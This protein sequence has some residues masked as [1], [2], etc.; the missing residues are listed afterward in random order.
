MKKKIFLMKK[1][2]SILILCAFTMNTIVPPSLAQSI[3]STILPPVGSMLTMT[4]SFVP[5]Q[6]KGLTIDPENPLHFEFIIDTGDSKIVNDEELRAET[7]KLVKYFLTSLTVPEEDMWVNLSP[8][9]GNRIVTDGFG[10][11]Q[12][13]QDLLAQDYILKQITASL[14]FP[15]KELGKKFWDKI[16]QRAEQEYGTK[17]IPTNT[18]NKVWIIPEKATVY[19]HDGSV[20]VIESRLK[21]LLE[22]DY[23][24]QRK[25]EGASVDPNKSVY[26]DI[27]REI[28]I[29]EIEKEVNE[30]QHFAKLRQIYNAMIL[31]TWYKTN[32]QKSVLGQIYVDQN[33]LEGING[34]NKNAKSD[35]YN[36]YLKAFKAGVYNYI[37][38]D[39]D[40][41]TRSTIPRQY[42]SGG[43]AA[44][45]DK[46]ALSTVV[47]ESNLGQNNTPLSDE[48]SALIADALSARGK[49]FNTDIL[50]REAVSGITS[51]DEAILS[52]FTED[53]IVSRI[54]NTPYDP[55]KIGQQ[56]RAWYADGNLDAD[57]LK[58]TLTNLSRRV[59]YVKSTADLKDY[60]KMKPFLIK[61][62]AL[63]K[64]ANDSQYTESISIIERTMAYS[65]Y[66]SDPKL[67]YAEPIESMVADLR[68]IKD[69]TADE[70]IKFDEAWTLISKRYS[71]KNP[72]DIF[73]IARAMKRPKAS[74]I[75]KSSL[76]KDF[77]ELRD[78]KDP[79]DPQ[80][81]ERYTP[82]ENEIQEAM[83]I[84][85][86]D[87]LEAR[88]YV[89]AKRD[90]QY[91]DASVLTGIGT[92]VD[93]KT[94]KET[95]VMVVALQNGSDIKEL[96]ER[97]AGLN[98]PWGYWKAIRAFRLAEST[99]YR[100]PIVTFVDTK[101]ADNTLPSEIANQSGVVSYAIQ[102]QQELTVPFIS[103][104]NIDGVSAGGMVVTQGGALYMMD[105][106][107]RY[108]AAPAGSLDIIGKAK[109]TIPVAEQRG[110]KDTIGMQIIE[111]EVQSVWGDAFH[112]DAK[113]SLEELKTISGIIPEA[114]GGAH[115]FPELS[116]EMIGDVIHNYLK[117]NANKTVAQLKAQRHDFFR[118]LGGIPEKDFRIV[119]DQDVPTL[120]KSIITPDEFAQ[121][122][123]TILDNKQNTERMLHAYRQYTFTLKSAKQKKE[124]VAVWMK[125]FRANRSWFDNRWMVKVLN[126]SL[127][128]F[129]KKGTQ[130][131]KTLKE[132]MIKSF[133]PEPRSIADRLEQFVDRKKDGSLEIIEELNANLAET[134][135]IDFDETIH[136]AYP[137]LKIDGQDIAAKFDQFRKLTGSLTGVW[138]GYVKIGG[139]KTMLV[140]KDPR[141][142]NASATTAVIGEKV[143]RALEDVRQ[144][145]DKTKEKIPVIML[146]TASGAL[147]QEGQR[148]MD[149][150]NKKL[151][152]LVELKERNIPVVILG[153][154]EVFGG[155]SASDATYQDADLLLL[156]KGTRK[157]F[158]GHPTL[159]GENDRRKKK[160]V[161]DTSQNEVVPL[162]VLPFPYQTDQFL[163][164][165]GFIDGIVTVEQETP[166]LQA[167]LQDVTNK[168][169]TVKSEEI[170]ELLKT[171]K[172]KR[173][174]R[175]K[176]VRALERKPFKTTFQNGNEA[177]VFNLRN[178]A[179]LLMNQPG[180]GWRYEKPA[181]G[182]E[183]VNSDEAMLTNV[184]ENAETM[185]QNLPQDIE[186]FMM[187][188]ASK[189]NGGEA[190][191][192]DQK[193]ITDM[194]SLI[195]EIYEKEMDGLTTKNYHNHMHNLSVSFGSLILAQNANLIKDKNDLIIVFLGSLFHDFHVRDVRPLRER[196]PA[197]PALVN[198]TLGIEGSGGQL[199]DLLAIDGFV[200]KNPAIANARYGVVGT[201]VKKSARE[202]YQTLT[203][204]DGSNGI[205]N[206]IAAIIRRTD[207]SSDLPPAIDKYKNRTFVVRDF[208]DAKVNEWSQTKSEISDTDLTQ[209][210][211]QVEK[212][213]QDIYTDMARDKELTPV[214]KREVSEK[215]VTRQRNIE[216]A[217]LNALTKVRSSRRLN[218]YQIANRVELADQSVASWIGSPDIAKNITLG[219][220][221]E[222]PF[223][224]IEAN[225]PLFYTPQL[226]PTR[227]LSRLRDLPL[228]LR[229][230]FLKNMEYFASYSTDFAKNL[231]DEQKTKI[232]EF[233]YKMMLN[234]L[235]EWDK[236]EEDVLMELR[237]YVDEEGQI[238]QQRMDPEVVQG[239]RK[240]IIGTVFNLRDIHS[241]VAQRTVK[242][243]NL[244][245]NQTIIEE[246]DVINHK[247]SEGLYIIIS[248]EV[249]VIVGGS[250]VA[251]LKAGDHFGELA[252]ISRLP[253]N[254]T[255]VSTSPTVLVKMPSRFLHGLRL[256]SDEFSDALYAEARA[257]T[258]KGTSIL[259]YWVESE[260]VM[261][262]ARSNQILNEQSKILAWQM[263][264]FVR[265]NENKS[266]RLTLQSVYDRLPAALYEFENDYPEIGPIKL[267]GIASNG[268]SVS[269]YVDPIDHKSIVVFS[270][271]FFKRDLD[272]F[273][274]R[275]KTA[276]Q[277]AMNDAAM[278]ADDESPNALTKGGIDL[279]PQALDLKI[280]NTGT[281]IPF[282]VDENIEQFI[283]IKG[284]SPVIINIT[285]IHNL[286]LILGIIDGK[287][288]QSPQVK[289]D[290][291][292]LY[293]V[294][295]RFESVED[296]PS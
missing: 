225:Y 228:N 257:K 160:G 40:S 281:Q 68:K 16:Y 10:Q 247:N 277:T 148:A 130:N 271:D 292:P 42:F 57:I 121:L 103:I 119:D 287:N 233:V 185:Y 164:R 136:E 180:I 110:V 181:T 259:P 150:L 265:G 60:E 183:T 274:Q 173:E 37:K 32:L 218:V 109:T 3:S 217:F 266:E 165:L 129:E 245:A 89:I 29:P 151:A 132:A 263:P 192:N 267:V 56:M 157:G 252:I 133:F 107:N 153:A 23:F 255:V 249:K 147:Q 63:L 15:E 187:S 269:V 75:V 279:N 36:Q 77:M 171:F 179:R 47:K 212:Q 25:S 202:I 203:G 195:G 86:K 222:L 90:A 81:N 48:D 39:Y 34:E 66:I 18:F 294:K 177:E 38:E 204:N 216:L 291:F 112:A 197:T 126:A 17:D 43:F 268:P 85:F 158:T 80:K 149:P 193:A 111:K 161:K 278:F 35:I 117:E 26:T 293:N 8:Y 83:S 88:E 123:E 22:E 191:M 273:N 213:Y 169:L 127:T 280:K 272:N 174:M 53:E 115:R 258:R 93:P 227:V 67:F 135:I 270:D 256:V 46:A 224:S 262:M 4:P 226:L 186:K 78:A 289:S 282:P 52:S 114:L 206:E 62:W 237:L 168:E 234:S 283:D 209:L 30:G 19:E 125:V 232:N 188:T 124:V 145:F 254:A 152:G 243:I 139:V 101:G 71:Q 137:F 275:I 198:E 54:L 118:R 175:V 176:L 99:E 49:Q 1:F 12:M 285:P 14:M 84:G 242:K 104:I 170:K 143:T 41:T 200:Y 70:R 6:I 286:P 251:T 73:Y 162:T 199:P 215:W 146:T 113:R 240:S 116:Y 290:H 229:I 201:D 166:L 61:T 97:N 184:Y 21:V 108:L 244:A 102:V 182:Q 142:L 55:I 45:S 167:F 284:F 13:G 9:E 27:V 154:Y 253:R 140:L 94:G 100:I 250:P 20:F 65:L 261:K 2:V 24:A 156:E 134:P 44:T 79:L 50:L 235:G 11:T 59:V 95:K 189:I 92:F 288:D 236:I 28:L 159:T 106:S 219:L 138:T 141:W 190:V 64:E 231:N 7:T 163:D 210:I 220:K 33:K 76:F 295:G 296:Y 276:L 51:G 178:K 211:N 260:I 69:S 241:M 205:Y 172:D 31:A 96:F 207:F 264:Q 98:R 74:D 246:G 214:G 91:D 194:M 155:D 87:K 105:Y 144:K 208:M 122:V 196:G 238:K 248:G 128:E 82:T 72:R 239:L 131:A 223:V 221:E 230:N 58:A 120:T 5:I